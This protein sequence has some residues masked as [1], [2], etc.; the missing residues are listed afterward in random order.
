MDAALEARLSKLTPEQQLQYLTARRELTAAKA[1]PQAAPQAEEPSFTDR[2]GQAMRR[3]PGGIGLLPTSIPVEDMAEMGR[4]GIQAA[5]NIGLGILNLLPQTSAR[6]K[7]QADKEAFDANASDM[8]LMTSAVAPFLG[9]FGA[10]AGI[11]KGLSALPQLPGGLP[12]ISKVAA[13]ALSGVAGGAAS[14]LLSGN[15]PGQVVDDAGEAGLWGAGLSTGGSLLTSATK[16]SRRALDLMKRK[17]L[18]SNGVERTFTPTVGQALEAGGI[19]GAAKKVEEGAASL[20]FVGEAFSNA[21]SRA[22]KEGLALAMDDLVG[23]GAKQPRLAQKSLE[24]PA[25]WL[26]HLRDTKQQLYNVADESLDAVVPGMEAAN[27]AKDVAK[28]T[29]RALGADEVGLKNWAERQFGA[30]NKTPA[31]TTLFNLKQRKQNMQNRESEGFFQDMIDRIRDAG[32]ARDPKTSEYL[33]IADRFNKGY[34]VIEDWNPTGNSGLKSL[35]AKASKWF[36]PSK[37]DPI[38]SN[39][40]DVINVV[41]DK[42]A[43]SGTALRAQ[44]GNMLLHGGGMVG[45]ILRTGLLT[46]AVGGG[47]QYTGLPGSD[48]LAYAVVGALA[49]AGQGPKT[50]R[51]LIHALNAVNKSSKAAR[52]FIQHG[53]PG[54]LSQ[55]NND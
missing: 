1:A 20:P 7:L 49:G 34:K 38:I 36:P 26:P 44:T 35:R 40:D 3:V 31:S 16:I 28:N 23:T 32:R 4:G 5:K 45:D 9:G 37:G 24:D 11:S 55:W 30:T 51:A 39:M 21:R 53:V 18:D 33:D 2:V 22:A 52:P 19:S 48:P 42:V 17:W 8:A 54:L 46:G 29:P 15:T 50:Q 6:D 41:G 13:D 25:S 14:S 27:M 47:A 43:D 12:I 10:S